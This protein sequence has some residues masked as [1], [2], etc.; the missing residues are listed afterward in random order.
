MRNNIFKTFI[1]LCGLLVTSTM[2]GQTDDPNYYYIITTDN[3]GTEGEAPRRANIKEVTSVDESKVFYLTTNADESKKV[4][5]RGHN[6]V[7]IKKS[8]VFMNFRLRKTERD[9]NMLLNSPRYKRT[10]SRR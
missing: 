5:S 9:T 4:Y 6:V 7:K 10:N 8:R 2:T 3:P 1:L